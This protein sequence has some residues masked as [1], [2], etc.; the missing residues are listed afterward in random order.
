MAQQQSPFLE[1][2]YGWNFG[3]GGWNS[4]MDQNL[5]KFSFMFDRNVDS[6]VA[7][8]PAAANGQAHYLTTDNR[9]YFAVGTTYLSSPVPNWFEFKVR[10]TGATYQFNGTSKYAPRFPMTQTEP[11]PFDIIVNIKPNVDAKHP[12]Y[13]FENS[14]ERF[15]A[16]LDADIDSMIAYLAQIARGNEAQEMQDNFK[17]IVSMPRMDVGQDIAD[18]SNKLHKAFDTRGTTKRM[19][20]PPMPKEVSVVGT[21]VVN[22]N[23]GQVIADAA[24][25]AEKQKEGTFKAE[26]EAPAMKDFMLKMAQNPSQPIFHNNTNVDYIEAGKQYGNPEVFFAELGTLMVEMKEALADSG[27]YG[28]DVLKAGNLFFGGISIDKGYGGLHIK[29]PYKAVLI[30]PFYDFGAKT[31]FG[32]AEFMWETMTHE[33]AHTGDMEHGEVHNTHMLKV[34]QYLADEGLAYFYDAITDILRRHEATFTAMREAY[35]RSTTNNTGKS[36]EDYGK[37]S[38]STQAGGIGSSSDSMSFSNRPLKRSRLFS[39]G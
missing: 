8:L 9:L 1:A 24:K 10:S 20:L 12:D 15:K 16:R 32:A 22:T 19:E 11:I 28:Y 6:I 13:P 18:A 38:A 35:G 3:E 26:Q 17:N 29:V 34:R 31:L 23:T 4:G 21:T 36:L 14:R 25:K 33:V 37:G 2:A 30:N 27:F 7:S 39:N 5:L